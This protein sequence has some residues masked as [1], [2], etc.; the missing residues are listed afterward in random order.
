MKFK[1]LRSTLMALVLFAITEAKPTGVDPHYFNY[2]NSYVVN[3][4][5]NFTPN[6]VLVLTQT[7]TTTYPLQLFT[8]GTGTLAD[9]ET[10]GDNI[11]WYDAATGATY[12]QIPRL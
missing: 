7:P 3:I 5:N 2:V 9:L 11:Q 8:T 10:T 1:L 4:E 12:W 6:T